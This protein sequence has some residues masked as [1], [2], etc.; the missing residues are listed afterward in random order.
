[1]LQVSDLHQHSRNRLQEVPGDP[2]KLVLIHTVI[3][4]GSSFLLAVI[5]YLFDR[6][7]E[8]TGGL[9]GMGLRSIL[10]TARDVL[11]QI[12]LIG[13]PFWQMGIYYAALHW[14]KGEQANF[15]SLLQGFHRFGSVLGLLLLRSIIYIALLFAVANISTIIFMLTPFS[16][17][18]TDLLVPTSDQA[19]MQEQLE[20]LMT[21]EGLETFFRAASPLFIIFGVLYAVVAIFL[22]YR[23]RFADFAVMDGIAAVRAILKS[24]TTTKGHCL[25]VLKIDLSFWWFYVLQALSVVISN[26][27]T[28]LLLLNVPLP[29]PDIAAALVFNA[30]G[31]VSQ[32]VLL[33]QYEGHRITVYGLA[34]RTLDGSIYD[35]SP[36]M[37]F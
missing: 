13:L 28:I 34:Y 37:Q 35:S 9:G 3:A 30:L 29:V 2:K 36:E 21:P 15:G 20:A 6:L 16:G 19:A 14:T 23:L 5:T 12:V 11:N 18:L 8:G 31:A 1:M 7:I 26:M 17:P 33:W 4:L 25:Q 22:F 27:G 24:F 10:T 32:A